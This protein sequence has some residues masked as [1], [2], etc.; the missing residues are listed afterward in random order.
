LY[1][2]LSKSGNWFLSYSRKC[3]GCFFGTVYNAHL[4]F[5]NDIWCYINVLNNGLLDES[6]HM[7]A[8]AMRI[9][10]EPTAKL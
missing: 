8:R 10:G 3:W 2:K 9:F 4:G 5:I 6:S 1:R 7:C